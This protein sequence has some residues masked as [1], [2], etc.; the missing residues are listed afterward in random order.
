LPE[1]HALL[2]L[3]ARFWQTRKY[4]SQKTFKRPTPYTKN[5][6]LHITTLYITETRRMLFVHWKSWWDEQIRDIALL[7]M[8]EI[9]TNK[10]NMDTYAVNLKNCEN[11]SSIRFHHVI[12]CYV[13]DVRH[14]QNHTV[15]LLV[16]WRP[17]LYWR[18]KQPPSSPKG[19]AGADSMHI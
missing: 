11:V 9:E 17:P 4:P 2:A 16:F 12:H 7:R 6:T 5:L 19:S 13:L 18:P 1:G 10:K 14:F 8:H 3:T 15:A